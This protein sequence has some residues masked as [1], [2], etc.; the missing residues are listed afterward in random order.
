MIKKSIVFLRREYCLSG[1]DEENAGKSPFIQLHK[2]LEDA[3][4]AEI[5]DFNAIFLAT[6]GKDGIPSGRIVLLKSY[7]EEGLIFF[8]NYE[9]RKGREMNE[10]PNVAVTFY[11]KEIERQVRI[12]GRVSKLPAEESDEY[13][14]SRPAGSRVSAIVS[15]QSRIIKR[16][17][18][19]ERLREDFLKEHPDDLHRP[20]YW[21][22]YRIKPFLFEFWQ[23]REH[24]F[25][26]R[27]QYTL[28][29]EEWIMERLA[30]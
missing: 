9:S 27:L 15:P 8:T 29:G 26:D 22:G 11:W 17:S 28:K 30:P 10:N 19:L 3:Q 4:N 6:A 21:G 7:D 23:G 13:F 2:W 5:K 16:R 24:R 18:D 25:H 20:D 12:Q 1:L 14:M